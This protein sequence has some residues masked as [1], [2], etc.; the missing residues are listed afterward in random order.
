MVK[1]NQVSLQCSKLNQK[2]CQSCCL[3]SQIINIKLKKSFKKVPGPP[4][5]LS[6]SGWRTGSNL[7]HCSLQNS[8]IE[9]KYTQMKTGPFYQQFF[10]HN[11]NSMENWSYCNSIEGYHMVQLQNSEHATT[12]QLSCHVQNSI[13]ITSLQ[14]G[15]E[16][17]EISIEFE[18][19]CKN[20]SWTPGVH[21]SKA[22]FMGMHS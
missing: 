20:L 5:K 4:P 3:E 16:Q 17:N 10:H 11:S 14:F 8:A 12:A 15:W 19:R 1:H 2:S 6:A 7:E 9:H 22:S 13:A 18:L 21:F